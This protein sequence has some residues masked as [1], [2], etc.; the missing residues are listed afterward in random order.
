[1]RAMS[2]NFLTGKQNFPSSKSYAFDQLTMGSAKEAIVGSHQYRTGLKH[3]NNV[4]GWLCA[5]ASTDHDLVG[6]LR[7]FQTDAYLAITEMASAHPRLSSLRVKNSR[8][9][10]FMTFKVRSNHLD[11]S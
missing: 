8:L 2:R 11:S 3:H 10:R 9:S 6:R 5:V 7:Y 1:M 4:R